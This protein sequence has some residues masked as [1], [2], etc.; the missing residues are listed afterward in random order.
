MTVSPDPPQPLPIDEED[1]YI[2]IRTCIAKH[3]SNFIPH[4]PGNHIVNAKHIALSGATGN[5][6]A[7]LLDQL[8][9][10]NDVEKIYLLNRRSKESAEAS[11]IQTFKAKGLDA[12]NFAKARPALEYLVI[13]FSRKDL[14]L[15]EAAYVDL[16]NNVTHIIHSAWL[17]NF[18]LDISAFERTHISGVR[19]LI[20]LAL[21][22]PQERTPRLTFLSTIGASMAYQGVSQIPEIGDKNGEIII[23]EMPV[24]DPSIPMPIG[25][26][27]SKYIS[28][29][30]LVNAEMQAGL[31]TTVI[32]VGQLAGMSTNGEWAENE[33]GMI[34]VRTSMAI[35]IYP[36]GLPSFRWMPSDIAASAIVKQSFFDSEPLQYFS[37]ENPFPTRN[38]EITAAIIA[39]ATKPMRGLHWEKW[40]EYLEN[41]DFDPR[42]VPGVLLVFIFRE[43]WSKAAQSAA[44]GW[45]RSVKV[46]PELIV[47]ELSNGPLAREMISRYIKY[48]MARSGNETKKVSKL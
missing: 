1:S 41:G 23:P 42:K 7:S 31:R 35:G 48:W 9:R 26:A 40:L 32:R 11:L 28:E 18:M 44:M 37:I 34:I 22:S 45:N 5:V 27:E 19:Q 25:Y 43:R 33:A 15:S 8:M 39:N 13:D 29:R 20:D 36:D 46:A 12:A 14:G 6:G 21:S 2:H 17:L 30:I 24:D 10:R 16:R 4:T 3:S 47:P 38:D